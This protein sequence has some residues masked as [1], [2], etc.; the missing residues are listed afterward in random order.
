MRECEAR[1]KPYSG[2]ECEEGLISGRCYY[3]GCEM[4]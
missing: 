2:L 3:C 1:D 4:E